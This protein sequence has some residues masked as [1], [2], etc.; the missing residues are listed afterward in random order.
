MDLQ[1]RLTRRGEWWTVAEELQMCL[2]MRGGYHRST[3]ADDTCTV[4][5][6]LKEVLQTRLFVV[7]CGSAGENDGKE[8]LDLLTRRQSIGMAGKGRSS[9]SLLSL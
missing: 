3:P 5:G 9:E 4:L 2:V 6:L 7:T 8:G 1:W